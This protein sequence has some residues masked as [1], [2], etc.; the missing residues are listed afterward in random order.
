MVLHAERQKLIMIKLLREGPESKDRGH[1]FGGLVSSAVLDFTLK[2]VDGK[3]YKLSDYKFPYLYDE[4]QQI[5]KAYSA[6]RTPEVF[7]FDQAARSSG[8]EGT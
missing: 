2:G 8:P 4:T 6:Q 5:A 1:P 7:L 3:T